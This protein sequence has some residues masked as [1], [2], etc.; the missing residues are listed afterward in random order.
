MQ[1]VKRGLVVALLI[2]ATAC[3]GWT[4]TDKTLYG[5]FTGAMAVD[6]LQTQY[7]LES[8][9]YR[10]LNPIIRAA[11]KDGAWAY[12]G[13]ATLGAYLVAD[14]LDKEDRTTFLSIVTVLEV[15]CIGRNAYL[16]IGFSF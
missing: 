12:F 13:L 14:A 11:G 9:D 7:I 15:G 16:G 1:P 10:E 6:A 8:E 2:L 5:T 3:A 4:K